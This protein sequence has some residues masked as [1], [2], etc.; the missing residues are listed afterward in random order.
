MKGREDGLAN[1]FDQ[2]QGGINGPRQ[3]GVI[4]ALSDVIQAQ[5]RDEEGEEEGAASN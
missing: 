1:K 2:T 4:R 5:L 3:H